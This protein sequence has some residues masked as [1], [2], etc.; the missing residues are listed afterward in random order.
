[1]FR[2][3]IRARILSISATPRTPVGMG[4]SRHN[5]DIRANSTIPRGQVTGSDRLDVFPYAND[6]RPL[7]ADFPENLYVKK[8]VDN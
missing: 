4:T 6:T 5:G 8:N 2:R 7:N 1:M 3:I